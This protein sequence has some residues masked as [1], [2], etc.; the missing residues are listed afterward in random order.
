MDISEARELLE[1]REEQLVR[2]TIDP[3]DT[4]VQVGMDEGSIML[5]TGDDELFLGNFGLSEMAR[6]FSVSLTTFRR[7]PVDLRQTTINRMMQE[8]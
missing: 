2:V 6:F 5:H 1:Q 8:W 3:R 4:R 7:F